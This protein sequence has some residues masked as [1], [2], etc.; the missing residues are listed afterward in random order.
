ML[1]RVESDM[2]ALL[3][4]DMVVD[5]GKLKALGWKPR[6][7]TFAE[8]FAHSLKWYQGRRWLPTYGRSGSAAETQR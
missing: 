5:C 1:P 3:G 8:G 4:E 2:L 6:F 7:G